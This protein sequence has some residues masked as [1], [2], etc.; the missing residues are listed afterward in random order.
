MDAMTIGKLAKVAG[1]GVETI[2]FCESGAR[3]INRADYPLWVIN[4]HRIVD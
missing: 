3:S 2:R 1:V 4:G